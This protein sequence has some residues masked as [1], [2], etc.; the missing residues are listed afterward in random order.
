M[1]CPSIASAVRG[2]A[3][4]ELAVAL[5][6]GPARRGGG[7]TDDAGPRRP[8]GVGGDRARR[9]PDGRDL[10]RAR[11]LDRRGRGGPRARTSPGHRLR[12]DR[13]RAVR[14][15]PATATAPCAPTCATAVHDDPYRHV[16]RQ[17]LTAH[18]DVTA[19][20]RA[21]AAAGLAHL[22]TTT[23]AE[24][25]VGAGTDE[26]LRAIQSGSGDLARGVPHGP[27][28][29]DALARSGRDGSLPRSW[30][31]GADWPA[32]PP[33]AAFAYR[34]RERSSGSAAPSPTDAC[35]TPAD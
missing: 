5:D 2:D 14:S 12:R 34:L 26:L 22:A 29:V 18:V 10:P 21:A 16:G 30:P 24:F 7:R 15:G 35:P 27:F 33:L 28:G 17:D 11:R 4:L 6:D 9:R 32:G 31:S 1:P 13:D 8:P 23:Q 25:L 3:L 19:V 20:E